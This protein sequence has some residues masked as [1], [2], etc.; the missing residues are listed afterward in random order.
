MNKWVYM[1]TLVLIP[2]TANK[3]WTHPS[4]CHPLFCGQSTNKILNLISHIIQIMTLQIF[5]RG[6][7]LADPLS[8]L[9]LKAVCSLP[10]CVSKIFPVQSNKGKKSQKI[11][12]K[13]KKRHKCIWEVQFSHLFLRCWS[14]QP[15][16]WKSQPRLF[17]KS[18]VV[19]RS[20]KLSE[21]KP[22]FL[23]RAL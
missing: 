12:L 23:Q 20:S 6:K 8:S 13:A 19:V 18:C 7:S 17:E 10:T 1:F 9:G 16:P 15:Q 21:V 11:M 14:K 22:M 4:W 2:Q 5:W 3:R